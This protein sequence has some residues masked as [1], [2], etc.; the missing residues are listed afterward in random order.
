MNKKVVAA[1][2]ATLIIVQFLQLP[3]DIANI[4]RILLLAIGLYIALTEPEDS[5][6]KPKPAKRKLPAK[7]GDKEDKKSLDKVAQAAEEQ[8]ENV[9]LSAL[10]LDYHREAW[11]RFEREIDAVL[12]KFLILI[13]ER[14]QSYTT[15]IF[16]PDNDGA[17]TLRVHIS[18][19]D[20]LI[21]HAQVVPGYG[22]LGSYLKEGKREALLN[23]MGATHELPYH[24]QRGVVRS[25]IMAPIIAVK[26]AGF[27]VVDSIESNKF[28]QEDLNW[29]T[30]IGE[31]GGGIIYYGYLYQQHRL[32]HEEIKALSERSKIFMSVKS[33]D[34]FL[35]E[36]TTVLI[37]AFNFDRLT[38]SIRDDDS[39]KAKIYRSMGLESEKLENFVFDVNDISIA[40]LFYNQRAENGKLNSFNRHF[41]LGQYEIR[42]NQSEP[43][44]SLFKSFAAFPMG[45]QA[46]RAL[47]MLESKSLNGFTTK[48]M[49]N[50]NRIIS[51]ASI[52]LEK[53]L[54]FEQQERLAIRDGLTGLYN[55]RQFHRL[56]KESIARANR[57]VTISSNQSNSKNSPP[58][59]QQQ[60]EKE[61]TPL[62][63][64]LCDID[65]FKRLNDNHGHRFGDKVL[66]EIAQTLEKGVRQGV[67][68]A[69]RYGGEEF[70]LILFGSNKLFAY[71]TTNRVRETIENLPLI[72]PS[73]EAITVTMSFG[74]AMY[75]EDAHEPED[76]IVKADKALYRAKEQGRNRVEYF[77]DEQ[78]Q[79]QSKTE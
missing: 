16:L 33:L 53:I 58:T 6:K 64:V 40:N 55:H 74:I 48:D 19:D 7:N 5:E 15:A 4:I 11:E 8:V 25:L 31:L 68:F 65:F 35:E 39:T 30:E 18:Q 41:N 66:Q 44:T 60:F 21:P 70:A 57:L 43:R 23:D 12:Y 54:L 63:L 51:A 67:D 42:Y 24:S 50:I 79:Q 1:I 78:K 13:E 49:E 2:L 29:I 47:I 17:Y 56:L 10:Q 14:F 37:E 71:E 77:R 32:I 20:N 27:I 34:Q 3:E 22:I 59:D 61:Q 28:T 38:I 45:M 46:T 36:L 26:A 62:A 72:A 69:A 75:G 76:L 9:S 52:A 73:G